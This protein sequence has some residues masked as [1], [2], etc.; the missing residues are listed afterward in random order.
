MM[1]LWAGFLIMVLLSGCGWNGTPTRDNDITPLTSIEIV[2]DH[3]TIAAKTST[4]LSVKGNYMGLFTRDIT[5]Q[6]V[7]SSASPAVAEFL[8]GNRVTGLAPG[9]ALL[10][11]T[12][13]T[14][15]STFQLTVSSATITAMAVTP[16]A[17]SI[18]KGLNTQF[19]VSGTFSDTTTQDL[20]FDADWTSSHPAV[21]SISNAADSKGFARALAVGQSTISASFDGISGTTLLTVSEAAL[22]SIAVTTANPSALSLSKAN[23]LAN[24]TF[25]DGTTADITSQATWTSS[26]TDIATIAAGG[27]ATTLSQ[28]TT[29][30]SASLNGISGASNFKVTGGNL[31]GITFSPVDPTLVNGTVTPITAIG[32]FSNGSERDISGIVAWSVA[33]PGIAGVTTPGGNLALLTAT[34]VTPAGAPATI[35]A[36]HGTMSGTTG[37]TVVAPVLQTVAITPSS[38]TLNVGTSARF[39]A[40]ATFSDG[41]TQDVTASSTWT[42]NAPETVSVGN[43]TADSSKGRVNGVAAGSA[44]VT[45]TYGSQTRTANVTVTART[46]RSLAINPATATVP[47]GD[48]AVFTAIATYNDGSTQDVTEDATWSIDKPQVAVLADNTNQRGEIV[49]VDSGSANLTAQFGA[50]TQ[51]IPVLVP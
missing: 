37:L 47:S 28:G 35:T 15:S 40:T 21:A 39:T 44:T 10:T 48:Q 50:I 12:V 43:S 11:A 8:S 7:W 32:S 6:A 24:A 51:T 4:K 33:A 2:A 41:T 34:A 19:T 14:V 31:T 5:T 25:S 3:S 17:P 42:S 9:T 45:A 18:A 30:I 36:Q 27:T 38:L 46:I 29:A 22:Q 13:G 20:T 23:F 49:A 26:R 16:T 1:N